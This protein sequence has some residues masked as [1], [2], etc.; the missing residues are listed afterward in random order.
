MSGERLKSEGRCSYCGKLVSKRAISRHLA[1]HLKQ[2]EA[3]GGAKQHSFHIEVTAGPFFL[4]L[5]VPATAT[6]KKLDTFLRGIWLE[7]CGHMSA[8]SEGGWGS[9]VAMTRKCADVFGTYPKLV[10]RYDFGS[11]TELEVEVKESYAIETKSIELLSRNEPLAVMCATCNKEPAVAICA[12]HIY[13]GEG[14]F[15]ENCADK[16]EE[17]CEDFSDYAYMPVVN[18]PRAGVCAYEG[19]T[20]D[21]ERDGVFSK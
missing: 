17:E 14:V 5:L 21:V 9:D 18:S 20:I 19:G 1:Q 8:F 6:L 10:Y 7:C 13:E 11:T 3:Q 12:V 16:H 15:C 2:I 4:H